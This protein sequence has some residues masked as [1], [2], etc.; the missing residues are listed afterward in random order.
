MSGTINTSRRQFLKFSSGLTVGFAVGSLPGCGNAGPD[1]SPAG[2]NGFSPNGQALAPHAVYPGSRQ[3]RP[4]HL[5]WLGQVRISNQE[6]PKIF[7][8]ML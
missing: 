5:T 6:I 3:S 4:Q 1:L 2:N 7:L 8:L